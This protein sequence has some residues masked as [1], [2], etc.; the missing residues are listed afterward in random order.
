MDEADLDL[1]RSAPELHGAWYA[2]TYRDVARLGAD[3]A[4]HRVTPDR[5]PGP[6]FRA[7][8]CLDANPD[9]A[10]GGPDRRR[11]ASGAKGVR[12]DTKGAG[13]ADGPGRCGADC[14]RALDRRGKF[15]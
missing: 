13:G 6:G 3:P 8:A 14:A 9:V 10:G 2:R 7:R 12:E 11:R 15:Q 5:D 1:V 4:R